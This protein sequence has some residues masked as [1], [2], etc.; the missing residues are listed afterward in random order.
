MFKVRLH[1]S[2]DVELQ[3]WW[4]LF[5]RGMHVVN[6]WWRVLMYVVEVLL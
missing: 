2:K 1:R 6:A 3:M 5:V 4:L